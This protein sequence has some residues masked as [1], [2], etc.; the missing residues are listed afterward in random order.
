M[1]RPATPASHHFVRSIGLVRNVASAFHGGNRDVFLD[2]ELVAKVWDTDED[3]PTALFIDTGKVS[4]ER[5]R[6]V[7]DSINHEYGGRLRW[8]ANP[9]KWGAQ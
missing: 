6:Q 5:S 2:R 4:E 9:A 1:S 3:R 8:V 7:M